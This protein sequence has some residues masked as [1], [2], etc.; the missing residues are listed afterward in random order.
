MIPP[1]KQP[2]FDIDARQAALQNLPRHGVGSPGLT[3]EP[4]FP[5][6]AFGARVA[7]YAIDIAILMVLNIGLAIAG[8]PSYASGILNIAY[9]I[10]SHARFA[11]TI[12]KKVVG[13]QLEATDWSELTIGQILIR[14]TIGRFISTAIFFFGYLW[15]AFDQHGQTWHD[16]IGKTRVVSS[17]MN[18]SSGSAVAAAF[19]VLAIPLVFGMV[20]YISLFSPIPLQ[21]LAQEAK[22]F[23]VTLE[24]IHGSVARGVSVGL[25]KYNNPFAEIELHDVAF[26]YDLFKIFKENRVL[27]NEMSISSGKIHV[28]RI[29]QHESSAGGLPASGLPFAAPKA[30][31]PK[32]APPAETESATKLKMQKIGAI[33]IEQI[34]I[35][36]LEFEIPEEAAA[37]A[38]AVGGG[39][40]K[41]FLVQRF[42][43]ENLKAN[44]SGLK[45][46]RLVLQSDHISIDA[47]NINVT[48]DRAA[49]DGVATG[50]IA[51]L[52]WPS[53]LQADADLEAQIDYNISAKSLEKLYLA[54]LERRLQLSKES[55][56]YALKAF[57]LNLN[58]YLKT[59]PP[60]E[61]INLKITG[62]MPIF[63]INV[64]FANFSLRGKPFQ[65]LNGDFQF[66]RNTKTYHLQAAPLTLITQ[67]ADA[68]PL[69]TIVSETQTYPTEWLAELYFE[70]RF[71]DLSPEQQKQVIAD[72]RFFKMPDDADKQRLQQRA[73]YE[74]Q[75]NMLTPA[76]RLPAQNLPTK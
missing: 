48:K 20:I 44:D 35:A 39:G 57:G 54:M 55:D 27:I 21:Q 59:T 37:M 3:E 50:K 5:N 19:G 51:Q 42:F 43:V 11:Q 22:Q 8:L 1:P 49:I 61:N 75:I 6:A 32:I 41:T 76:P 45:I 69:F 15:A 17:V 26:K 16:K 53:K 71:E 62:P 66:H 63:L 7:A 10:F 12:G 64:V 30:E 67:S 36:N 72:Q 13:I 52:L 9:F 56:G 25:I 68:K 60:I 70:R 31:P 73:Q 28:L 47:P 40:G 34:D 18:S 23:G 29:S 2:K 24:S 14:E 33:E 58:K 4:G 38:M 74:Q 46:D 65:Y